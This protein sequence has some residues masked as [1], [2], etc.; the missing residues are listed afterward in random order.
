LSGIPLRTKP[1][2]FSAPVRV[3]CNRDNSGPRLQMRPIGRARTGPIANPDHTGDRPGASTDC[4]Y[5]PAYQIRGRQRSLLVSA[6]VQVSWPW[7]R[8]M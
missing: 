7:P 1:S 5:H 6:T 2:M 3:R 4:A 8:D